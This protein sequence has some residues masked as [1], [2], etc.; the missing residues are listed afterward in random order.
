MVTYSNGDIIETDM[1]A[2]LTDQQIRDYF[3]IGRQFNVGREKD[4]IVSVKRLIY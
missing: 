3:K 4:K 1:A 2:Q